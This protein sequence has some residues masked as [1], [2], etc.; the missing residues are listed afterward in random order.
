MWW[1]QYTMPLIQRKNQIQLC[2][3][4]TSSN[5]C[6][7]VDSFKSQSSW[8]IVIQKKSVRR[9]DWRTDSLICTKNFS[10]WFEAASNQ[11]TKYQVSRPKCFED[12][13]IT[14]MCFETNEQT[15]L[16]Q[17]FFFISFNLNHI[18]YQI[19]NLQFLLFL[20]YCD[21]K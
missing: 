11:Y 13:S 5:I 2:S 7:K 9:T 20:R 8:D 21:T 10:W 1:E 12:I 6:T 15:K 4:Y 18:T 16:H 14:S 17:K 19:P 3:A